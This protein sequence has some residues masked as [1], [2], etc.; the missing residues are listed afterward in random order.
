MRER[1]TQNMFSFFCIYPRRP[2]RGECLSILKSDMW[3]L[4]KAALLGH[5]CCCL[6]Q[7]HFL[8]MVC[9]WMKS[10]LL[11][12]SL[13]P[14]P[15]I[16]EHWN[17]FF[18]IWLL[19][20]REQNVRRWLV[21]TPVFPSYSSWESSGKS[22]VRVYFSI[23]YHAEARGMVGKACVQPGALLPQKSRCCLFMVTV[24]W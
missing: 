14:F 15:I 5:M 19:I 20:F 17:T 8:G 21:A 7:I 6:L 12:K 10:L 1:K 16:V 3:Y 11:L 13:S 23:Q 24:K 9:I 18:A 2:S 22:R 4:N